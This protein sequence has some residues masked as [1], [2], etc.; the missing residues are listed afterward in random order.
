M[1]KEFETFE[2]FKHGL[3]KSKLWL[4]NELENIIQNDVKY[5]VHILA[6]WTNIL[7]FM[8]SVRKSYQYQ[9][10]HSYD[11]DTS[12][13]T[14]A[15]QITDAWNYEEPKIQ[16]HLVDINHIDYTNHE[17]DLIYINCSVEHL[18][19]RDWFS[20]IKKGSIVCLQA[21]DIDI[22]DHP[23]YIKDYTPTIDSIVDKYPLEQILFKNA[24]PIV[25][26]H[27]EYKRFM[28]I[29]IK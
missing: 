13:I 15:N 4:C 16:N 6:G 20:N 18:E 19:N 5:N 9:E 8:L 22:T 28:V 14:I 11:I 2:S 17:G 29:G 23:W 26:S 1:G 12:S 27:F 24:L 25:Y 21:T 10:I 3:I 7:G